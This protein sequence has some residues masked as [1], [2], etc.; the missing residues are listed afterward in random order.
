MPNRTFVIDYPEAH[1]A[2]RVIGEAHGVE[3]EGV[4]PAL[5]DRPVSIDGEPPDLPAEPF[6]VVNGSGNYHHETV[7]LVEG[8]LK[9]RDGARF[10]YVQIDA[11]P[12]KDDR[13]RWKCDCASFVGRVLRRP[14]IENVYLLGINPGCLLDDDRDD[15][16]VT[17]R[18]SY[19]GDRYFEKLREYV[20]ERDDIVEQFFKY[21]PVHL[22]NARSNPSVASVVEKEDVPPAANPVLDDGVAHPCLEV[23]W[24][25]LADFDADTLP[26]LPVY[27]TIDLDVCRDKPVTD[28]KE[29][30]TNKPDNRWGVPDNQGVMEWSALLEL[31][32]K[33]GA[34]REV[35]AADFCGLTK[36]LGEL[37]DDARAMSLDAMVEIYGAL[38]RAMA[39]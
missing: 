8:F 11:H 19:Y 30:D 31:V 13:F 24:K 25:T 3:A 12:D 36:R 23:R 4:L 20:I 1:E 33:I 5:G 7:P 29:R 9:A 38:S 27:L 22:E 16:L 15:R 10:T 14:E 34:A 26:D 35:V 6:I 39:R 37:R 21:N 32:E 18:L 17:P 2:M 28:W